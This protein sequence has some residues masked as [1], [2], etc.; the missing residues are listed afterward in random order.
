MNRTFPFGIL[1][2]IMDSEVVRDGRLMEMVDEK[3]R[4][5]KLPMED[6]AVP[7]MELPELEPDNG[8]TN[9]TLREQEQKWT[10][11]ALS[12]LHEQPPLTNCNS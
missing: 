8:P 5:D 12:R 6:I 1:V 7:Q 11:L 10:D 3:W 9:E 2:V 4:E